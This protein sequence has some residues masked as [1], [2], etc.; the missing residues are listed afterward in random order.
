[1]LGYEKRDL[2]GQ[3]LHE[4][5]AHTRMDGSSL[6]KKERSCTRVIATGKPVQ[7]DDTIWRSG[8]SWFN[9]EWRAL[10]IIQKGRT[11]G[12]VINYDVTTFGETFVHL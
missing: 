12:E 6:L 1:M 2:M 8:G 3:N 5:I 7:D 9:A 4:L 11:V 10:P